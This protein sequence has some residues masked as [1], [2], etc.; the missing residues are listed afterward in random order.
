MGISCPSRR[1]HEVARQWRGLARGL[2]HRRM[3]GYC[4]MAAPP[5]PPMTALVF[6]AGGA[7][8]N[9][10]FPV[11][12]PTLMQ[13]ASFLG[14]TLFRTVVFRTPP[15][16]AERNRHISPNETT[17]FRRMESPHFTERIDVQCADRQ[18]ECLD[19]GAEN[20]RLQFTAVRLMILSQR[21]RE[22]LAV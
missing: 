14:S 4:R 9:D 19:Y 6:R 2:A 22:F 1:G 10:G 3:G 21:R 11:Q 5:P 12:A 7:N 15:H 20:K 18:S 13:E 16:F 8:G 17:T